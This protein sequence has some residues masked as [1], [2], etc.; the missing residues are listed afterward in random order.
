MSARGLSASEPPDEHPLED[1][2]FARLI[3]SLGPFETAPRLAVAVSGGPDSLTLCLLAAKWAAA[4]GGAAIGLTVDHG[5]RADSAAEAALVGRWLQARGIAHAILAW[6]GPKPSSGVQARARAV[7]HRLLSAW[8]RERHV[9]HLLL[10]H[11]RDDQIETV[12]LRAARGSGPAG[13]AGM[14]AIREV[15]GLRLLRPLLPIAKARLVLT[16]QALGQPWLED[17]SNLD[18]RHARSA[19]RLAGPPAA[20]AEAFASVA[21]LG[22]QRAGTDR[23]LAAWLAR[24]AR[25]DP[26]GF[27]AIDQAAAASLDRSHLALVLRRALMTVG[28]GD[29]PPRQLRLEA[30]LDAFGAGRQLTRTLGGCQIRTGGAHLLILREA[31]AIAPARLV[32]APGGVVYDRRFT[33]DIEAPRPEV[34]V[35]P[36]GER[37]W[38]M[39]RGLEAHGPARPIGRAIGESLPALWRDEML[40]A[41]PQLGLYRDDRYPTLRI[42]FRPPYPLGGAPFAA[43]PT[44]PLLRPLDH[45]C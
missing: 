39:R 35:A 19:L 10:A 3:G 32:L 23:T 26:L 16:L 18:A 5:L 22:E 21:R 13:R 14:A 42:R 17:P 6:D 15:P 28:G 29:Y 7:R 24:H 30:L 36:L 4:R 20:P 25:T 45:L 33:I 31:R 11:H 9:L 27:V 43:R 37:G 34:A 38:M 44:L 1:A 8:C 12:R 40:V 2:D 41:V